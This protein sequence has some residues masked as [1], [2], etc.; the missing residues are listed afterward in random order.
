M[1]NGE[2]HDAAERVA[3]GAPLDVGIRPASAGDASEIARL[4]GELGYP[5]AAGEV[6]S[7]LTALAASASHFV[8]VAERGGAMVGWVAAEHRVSLESGARGEIVG[9]VVSASARRTGV[10]RALVFAAEAWAASR[11]LE[12]VLVRSNVARAASHPFYETSGYVRQK[13]QHVY[14]KSIA[15]P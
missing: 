11:G 7:R 1:G 5:C 10:G 2:G 15:G 9:L 13:T 14:A 6:A 12:V 4:C 8:A 3:R